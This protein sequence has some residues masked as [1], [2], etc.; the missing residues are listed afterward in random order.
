VPDA[1]RIAQA[2]AL[3]I[4]VTV[5]GSRPVKSTDER[6]LFT[7]TTTTILTFDSGAVLNLK[8]R[9]LEGQSLFLRNDQSGRE[10]L[11]KVL[12]TPPE[13]ETG[14]TDLE[15]TVIDPEFWGVQGEEPPA[16]VHRTEN[17]KPL[18]ASAAI[19]SAAVV[20]AAIPKVEP[21][22]LASGEIDAPVQE[23]PASPLPPGSAET[24]EMLSE[25]PDGP[26]SE[27]A[28]TA[29]QLAT[30][31]AKE[32]R[33]SSARR[34]SAAKEAKQATPG[35]ASD[36]APKQAES[37]AT[38]ASDGKAFSELAFRIRGLLGFAERKYLIRIGIAAPI[39]IVVLAGVAWRVKRNAAIHGNSRTA[40]SSAQSSRPA[41]PVPTQPSQTPSSAVAAAEKNPVTTTSGVAALRPGNAEENPGHPAT[42]ATVGSAAI[43]GSSQTASANA[44]RQNP[45]RLNT[46]E[47]VPAQIISEPQPAFPPWAKALELDGVVKLDALIDEKGN[48]EE[49]SPLSGPRA[50]QHAAETA[51]GLWIF[52]P[53]L[54]GGAPTSSH[55]VLTVEFQQ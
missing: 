7:E 9:V 2:T 46:H 52:E 36:L 20:P 51:V 49:V 32:S 6:E 16:D 4:P 30:M 18:E 35:N 37:G 13:G 43:A 47:T 44:K 54:S 12:E 48:I 29:E 31:L 3:E 53:A 50:L 41:A 40:A 21:G 17:Q 24:A 14:C 1:A 38:S 10:I 55:V 27:D 8:S 33:G 26:D 22:L 19:E 25:H 45:S 11:C 15:F 28:K 23:T 34:A 42:L 5:Q 39:L